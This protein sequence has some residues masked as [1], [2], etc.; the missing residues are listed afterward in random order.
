MGEGGAF[1]VA[2]PV[3]SDPVPPSSHVAWRRSQPV[4]RGSI[5]VLDGDAEA[6]GFL[7][8][9]LAPL[10]HQV[11]L[12]ANVQEAQRLARQTR[13]D[14]ALCDLSLAQPTQGDAPRWLQ[15]A[16]IGQG[17]V[18]FLRA[19][20]KRARPGAEYGRTLGKPWQ[21]DEVIRLVHMGLGRVQAGSRPSAASP[22]G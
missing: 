6:R 3:M 13:L 10:G 20:G 12:A 4:A 19:D 17:Q 22:R 14:L 5:L 1:H 21:A 9:L 16:G 2:L 7:L 8:R 11:H 18:V 15:E